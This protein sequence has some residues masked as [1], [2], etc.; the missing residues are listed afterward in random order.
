[1]LYLLD[2][3]EAADALSTGVAIA[4]ELQDEEKRWILGALTTAAKMLV[5]AAGDGARPAS[6]TIFERIRRRSLPA[7]TRKRRRR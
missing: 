6:G 1:M 4:T 2:L 3:L 5:D 7:P